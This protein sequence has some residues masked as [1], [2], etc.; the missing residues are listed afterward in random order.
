MV[1]NL[2]KKWLRPFFLAY[3]ALTVTV[4]FAFSMRDKI[5]FSGAAAEKS[6]AGIFFS[7]IYDFDSVDWLTENTTTM[8]RANECSSCQM[9]YGLLRVFGLAG[10]CLAV[11]VLSE[12]GCTVL[13]NET[14]ST[15]KNNI[16]LKL[17]I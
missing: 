13:K 8:R 12:S 11:I 6:D 5:C 14:A 4:S 9:R 3:L 7:S 16:P 1:I 15:K 10:V 17:R 2:R